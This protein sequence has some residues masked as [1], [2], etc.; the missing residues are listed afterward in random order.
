MSIKINNVNVIDDSRNFNSPGIATVGSGS[1]II[2]IN[3]NSGI[4][5]VGTA[6]T[7][8]GISGN[9]AIAGTIRANSFNVP[10]NVVSFTP[11]NG[12]TDLSTVLNQIVI[13][14]DQLVSLGST[15]ELQIKTGS[16]SGA[17]VATYG[18]SR[19]SL[20]S[21][22]KVLTIDISG[23]G[24][25]QNN[26]QYFPVLTRQA[27]FSTSG[28]FVGVNSTGAGSPSYSFTVRPYGLGD[29][30][31]GG[32]LI[33]QSGGVR[34][35][36]APSSTEIYCS[37]NCINCAITNANAQAAC[38]DWFIPTYSQLQ[39][40]GSVCKQY[41]DSV[42][43]GS[44]WSNTQTFGDFIANHGGGAC[45]VDINNGGLGACFSSSFYNAR[46]FRCFTY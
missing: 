22:K 4:V 24:Y 42:S 10:V 43:V 29:P 12:A 13:T 33:C 38:G 37:F 39:N 36:V 25:L 26:V 35:L 17:V 18:M 45:L 21:T 16:L 40:P 1:S 19:M 28:Q 44:Y 41:W 9:I 20:D 30:G 27:V 11:S 15:G 32:F 6:I 7:I 3:G 2:T 46:A 34:W 8:D 31:F 23:I 14:F 5:R